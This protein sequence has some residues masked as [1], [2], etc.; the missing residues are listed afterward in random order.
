MDYPGW[1]SSFIGDIISV[2][3]AQSGKDL[4]KKLTKQNKNFRL[5]EDEVI[6]S[7]YYFE[8]YKNFYK[9]LESPFSAK[10]RK[11]IHK[12]IYDGL[13]QNDPDLLPGQA[14]SRIEILSEVIK[15]FIAL[16][17]MFIE[18]EDRED[19]L[20]EILNFQYQLILDKS[21]PSVNIFTVIFYLST[22]LYSS[23]VSLLLLEKYLLED[24]YGVT[25]L[26]LKKLLNRKLNIDLPSKLNNY[27][28]NDEKELRAIHKMGFEVRRMFERLPDRYQAISRFVTV[29]DRYIDFSLIYYPYKPTYSKDELLIDLF[30]TF[31]I[32]EQSQFVKGILNQEN[33]QTTV[34]P[35][36]GISFESKAMHEFYKRNH[37]SLHLLGDSGV[38][39]NLLQKGN[40]RVK[41][42]KVTRISEHE[43]ENKLDL[44]RILSFQTTFGVP[45]LVPIDD[46][47][48]FYYEYKILYHDKRK[49]RY[50]RYS[51]FF[52]IPDILE[53]YID[54]TG[55]MYWA[56]DEDYVG[57]NDG[58]RRDMS[59]S[60]IYAF[61][62]ELYQ[63]ATKQN[64][65]V[66]LRFH[67]FSEEQVSSELVLIDDFVTGNS[68]TLRALFNPNN[69][70][71]FE[72]LDIEIPDFDKQKRVIIVITDGDLVL[73]G[74]TEREAEKMATLVSNPLTQVILFEME[75]HFSLGKAVASNKKIHSYS[76][77]EKDRMF[78]QGIDVIMENVSKSSF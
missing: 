28:D 11:S 73:D 64:K 22:V 63:E 43:I 15:E 77:K 38:S 18:N 39:K 9:R 54:N 45:V 1:S 34:G 71:H 10:D 17:R 48:Y 33:V 42:K 20:N 56:E 27:L 49:V 53:I 7:F 52:T 69:G 35:S 40:Y 4:H 41:I 24:N 62:M 74:R 30:D 59:L 14:L 57:F 21:T 47:D 50:R 78:Y 2:D 3:V 61:V 32:D 65:K 70:H 60:V 26:A 68:S 31:T 46:E 16:N 5:P 51:K 58:S 29:L 8:L 6:R 66:Y 44:S 55:S 25:E 19:F 37:P 36:S 67:S 12:A 72:N 76:V 23:K 13:V 75:Q